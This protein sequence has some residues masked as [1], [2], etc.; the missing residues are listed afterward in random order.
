MN[1]PDILDPGGLV[2]RHS[3]EIAAVNPRVLLFLEDLLDTGVGLDLEPKS[4]E[5]GLV[6]SA[7]EYLGG[8]PVLDGRTGVG[9][10]PRQRNMM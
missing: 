5:P 9:Q 8:E 2:G 4:I 3:Q 6:Q 7:W 10:Q 1:G